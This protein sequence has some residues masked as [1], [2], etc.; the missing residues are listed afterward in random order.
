MT[1]KKSS[2]VILLI[3]ALL[4]GAAGSYAGVKLAVSQS[5]SVVT[6]EE[7]QAVSTNED[8]SDL[9]KEEQQQFLESIEG[10]GE[11]AK[12]LQAYELIQENYVEEMD[13]QALIEGAIEGMLGTLE[14][15]YSS[16]MDIEEME[17]FNHSIESSF[18]GIGAEVSMVEGKVT[19]VA[20]LKDSPAEAAGLK[21][22]DQ[23][24]K[25]DDESME[26]LDLNEAVSKIRGEQGT[27]V[28]L[29]VQRPGV[30]HLLN[31]EVT[32]DD[33]PL[34]TVYAETTTV[35]GKKVGVIEISSFAE[36]TA[37]RFEEELTALEED[38]IEGLVIDVRGNPGGLLTSI[39]EILKN[40]IPDD[41]PMFQVEGRDGETTNYYSELE[42]PKDYPINVLI[43]EG[44]ASASEILAGAMKEAAGA[45]VIGTS[46]FGKG[47]VQQTVP[48]GDGSTVK[49]TMFKWLTPDGNWIHEKGVEP[50]ME[51]KQPDYFYTSPLEIEEALHIGQSSAKIK[52]AKIM[53]KG[54]GFEAG[55]DDEEFT[56]ETVSAVKQFQ[57]E[58]G[59][60]QTG[61]IDEE[62]AKLLE[63]VIVEKIRSGNNDKQKE[64]A[65][66]NLF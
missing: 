39:E 23:I 66:N 3:A 32:R 57:K 24:L 18:E 61:E 29:Q 28:K 19:I 6:T 59:L 7:Q 42:E 44:S 35:D 51:V 8:F 55:K 36:N 30:D 11:M 38:G 64:A 54:A 15:P 62:T 22:N 10:S 2:I 4:V 41:K 43:D 56:E 52:T 5:N 9:S 46:S 33:I 45:E 34:E 58:E 40:F 12:V 14:D 27:I 47:T 48:M 21:P 17:N 31:I 1:L 65:L 50:T 37:E 49:L 63:T 60:E 13:N 20:P 53:L 25:V 26:G 16:Y